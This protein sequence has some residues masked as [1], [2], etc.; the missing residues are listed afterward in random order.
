MSSH[1]A[2]AL[3]KARTEGGTVAVDDDQRPASADDAY[4]IQGEVTALIDAETVG[5]KLG[6]TTE[7]NYHTNGGQ[8]GIPDRVKLMAK[9]SF[10][11]HC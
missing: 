1:L 4:A 7:K 2:K 9:L 8:A 5:W 10:K 11:H 3:W 6:A